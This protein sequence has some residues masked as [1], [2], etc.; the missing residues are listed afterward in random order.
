MG[1][2]ERQPAPVLRRG[3]QD[4][5]F[6][7][8][9][10][11]GWRLPDVIVAPIASGAMFTSLASSFEELVK[12]GRVAP[13][14]VRFVGGQAAGCSPVATAFKAGRSDI[15][16]VR[17]PDTIVRSLAIGNPADGRYAVE[18]ARASAARSRR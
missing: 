12:L 17:T 6:E 3:Q 14:D 2:R 7:I 18:L 10:D 4:P 8:A 9:E 16:P 11:L 13:K 5:G 15:E 1:P